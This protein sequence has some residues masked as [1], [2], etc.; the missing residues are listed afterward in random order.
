MRSVDL[1][2]GSRL[3]AAGTPMSETA[4]EQRESWSTLEQQRYKK[5]S[6]LL[7]VSEAVS[8][9]FRECDT[10]MATK[11]WAWVRIDTQQSSIRRGRIVTE[12]CSTNFIDVYIGSYSAGIGNERDTKR[13]EERSGAIKVLLVPTLRRYCEKV[14][15]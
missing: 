8:S 7:T 12:T 1:S 4:Q 10:L 2:F 15:R 3:G 13:R 5:Q 14:S 11:E 9:F 6:P